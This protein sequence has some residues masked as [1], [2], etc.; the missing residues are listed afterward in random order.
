MVAGYLPSAVQNVQSLRAAGGVAGQGECCHDLGE[1]LRHEEGFLGPR[2][3]WL[4]SVICAFPA[5]KS[6]RAHGCADPLSDT[7][8]GRPPAVSSLF[9]GQYAPLSCHWSGVVSPCFQVRTEYEVIPN[10]WLASNCFYVL[11]IHHSVCGSCQSTRVSH[12]ICSV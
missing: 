11:G 4:R 1:P 3:L 10:S 9:C 12:V 6:C 2:I 8:G 7:L 5:M